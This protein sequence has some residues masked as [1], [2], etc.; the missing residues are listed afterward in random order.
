MHRKAINNSSSLDKR[1][2]KKKSAPRQRSA[3]F[4]TLTPKDKTRGLTLRA[5]VRGGGGGATGVQLDL[6]VLGHAL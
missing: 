2:T 3:I 4:A 6:P 1:G 5:P